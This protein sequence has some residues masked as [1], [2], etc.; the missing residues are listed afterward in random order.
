MGWGND[1]TSTRH[2]VLINPFYFHLTYHY[3][4]KQLSF[5]RSFLANT[6]C[7]CSYILYP[8]KKKKT[9]PSFYDISRVCV[10]VCVCVCVR[11]RERER[12][13]ER[14][15]KYR[16][17]HIS[18]ACRVRTLVPHSSGFLLSVLPKLTTMKCSSLR[19]K[20]KKELRLKVPLFVRNPRPKSNE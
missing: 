14:S 20:N 8:K 19:A 6:Q 15:N 9:F 18:D 7:P 2:L 12:E 3:C 11:E 13:R 1:L 16:N 4:D 5:L 10:C 17:C